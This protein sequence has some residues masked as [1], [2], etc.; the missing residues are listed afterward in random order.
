MSD[1][2]QIFDCGSESERKTQ[3]PAQVDSGPP[4]PVAP[5]KRERILIF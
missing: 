5:L 2:S 3:N 1:F 4:D